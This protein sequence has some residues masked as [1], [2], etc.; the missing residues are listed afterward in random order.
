[1]PAPL[2]LLVS[3]LAVIGLMVWGRM[4]A[5][6]ALLLGALL[7]G[8][9]SP[10]IPLE[11][12]PGAVATN[13][14]RVAGGVA[15][16]I[17][18]A[19]VIGECLLDS[20][21]AERISRQFLR[22]FGQQRGHFALWGSGYVL[23]VPVFFDTV[24]YLLVPLARAMTA[25]QGRN[26]AL[27]LSAVA[28]G[29]AA[30]H[31]FVP[32]TPGPL[33]VGTTLNVDLG[34]LILMGL[35]CALPASLVALSYA[36]WRE[37]RHPSEPK[38]ALG[39]TPEELAEMVQRPD[40]DLP[41]FGASMLPIVLPVALIATRTA[42]DAFAPGSGLA[43]AARFF[44]DPNFALL[45]SAFAALWLVKSRCRLGLDEVRARVD[46]AL[47]GAGPIIL[48]TA[49]GGAYGGMLSQAQIGASLQAMS[50]S[51]G[52]PV[53]LLAFGL[54]AILKIAQGSSTVAMITTASVV[55][56]V[57]AAAGSGLPHPV[58]AALAIGGGS[59]VVSW[60]NDS[61]FWVVGRMGG[62]SERETV[63]A[64]TIPAAIVGTV[65]F[66]VAFTLS[67]VVPIG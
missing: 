14:G 20:G 30:T 67:I 31:V 50:E 64:W 24:F 46:R 12:V 40:A 10:V 38:A 52:L 56:T 42:A 57:Y 49:A 25:R 41:G 7:V 36:V 15:I 66:L 23:S 60:M 16:V 26:Y 55:Q 37:R 18:L 33:A 8:I 44:G 54:A 9:L 3:M 2:I 63:A 43:A 62:F 17:A 58:Y 21:A 61:G 19:A 4:H 45:A 35:L 65:G 29:G 34:L 32:P 51:I 59:L 39:V 28:V 27:N 22:V 11:T 53:M 1:M 47:A 6:L 5:F 48:I 13:L